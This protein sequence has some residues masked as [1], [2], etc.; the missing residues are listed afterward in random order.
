MTT[1]PVEPVTDPG[2]H[3]DPAPGGV[4]EVDPIDPVA[5]GEDPGATPQSDP[6]VVPSAPQ[7]EPAPA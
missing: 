7:T 4:P 5:P 3:P 6:E 1:A 2:A